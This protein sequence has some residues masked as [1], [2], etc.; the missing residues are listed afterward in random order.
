MFSASSRAKRGAIYFSNTKDWSAVGA[1]GGSNFAIHPRGSAHWISAFDNPVKVLGEVYMW[2]EI[3]VV[4]RLEN[5]RA[6]PVHLLGKNGGELS[7]HL[8]FRVPEIIAF[9]LVKIKGVAY[10][11]KKKKI[12][13]LSG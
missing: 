10:K 4:C 8:F 12:K 7:P 11:K 5:I 1:A 2:G 13:I 6:T 9:S 3:V